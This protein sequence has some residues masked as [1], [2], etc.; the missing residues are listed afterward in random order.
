MLLY[1]NIENYQ[2]Y[3]AEF[4]RFKEVTVYKTK[5]SIKI[6]FGKRKV[7]LGSDNGEEKVN[8]LQL[9]NKVKRD[10][11]KYIEGTKFKANKDNIIYWSWYNDSSD[12]IGTGEKDID[13][14]KIDLTS[15]YWSKAI[16][17]GIISKDTA[18]YFNSLNFGTLKEKKSA[19]LKAL[20]S[21]ATVKSVEIYNNGKRKKDFQ[22]LIFNEDF[23]NLYMWICNEVANDMQIVLSKVNGI[24]YY[25]D[26]IFVN[27]KRMDEVVNLFK[28]MGYKCTIENHKGNLHI[29]KNISYLC[30]PNKDGKLIQYPIEN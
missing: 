5:Y 14:C 6:D 25:W 16:N 7:F 15:A 23:R 22:K 12:M 26:C 13:L 19:R 3:K 18:N 9:I 2:N 1:D 27:P 30:C 28:Y 21:L 20:G 8:V 24:Y 17:E 11:K 4:E 10:A 29:G